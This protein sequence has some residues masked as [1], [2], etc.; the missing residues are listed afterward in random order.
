M[1][2]NLA[3]SVRIVTSSVILN[4][5]DTHHLLCAFLSSPPALIN[6][7]FLEIQC[8]NVYNL[9]CGGCCI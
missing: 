4:Y 8:Y 3:G 6:L 2:T 9:N 5:K 7:C 1:Q